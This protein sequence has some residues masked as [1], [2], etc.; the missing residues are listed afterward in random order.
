MKGHVVSGKYRWDVT[1]KHKLLENIINLLPLSSGMRSH[2]SSKATILFIFIPLFFSG[3]NEAS[4]GNNSLLRNWLAGYKD[5]NHRDDRN[6]THVLSRDA[7]DNDESQSFLTKEDSQ[8]SYSTINRR[9]ELSMW[10]ENSFKDHIEVFNNFFNAYNKFYEHVKNL[11]DDIT[12]WKLFED[13]NLWY[14]KLFN[15]ANYLNSKMQT[16][17][18]VTDA[19]NTSQ[20]QSENGESNENRKSTGQSG[21]S[22]SYQEVHKNDTCNETVSSVLISV[23]ISVNETNP[24]RNFDDNFQ[25]G[26]NNN[27]TNKG[28]KTNTQP[29][30]TGFKRREEGFNDSGRVSNEA[31]NVGMLMKGFHELIRFPHKYD[32]YLELIGK[33][34]ANMNNDDRSE[35][36][37]STMRRKLRPDEYRRKSAHNNGVQS[38]RHEEKEIHT[39]PNDLYEIKQIIKREARNSDP[40]GNHFGNPLLENGNDNTDRLTERDGK[41]VRLKYKGVKEVDHGRGDEYLKTLYE[42]VKSKDENPGHKGN[43]KSYYPGHNGDTREFYDRV[44]NTPE[45]VTDV[46]EKN[47]GRDRLKDNGNSDPLRKNDSTKRRSEYLE[48]RTSEGRTGSDS[49]GTLNPDEEEESPRRDKVVRLPNGTGTSLPDSTLSDMTWSRYRDS[50]NTYNK[51]EVV[52]VWSLLREKCKVNSVKSLLTKCVSKVKGFLNDLCRLDKTEIS[53]NS[54][55]TSRTL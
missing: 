6:Y 14:D 18:N 27:K 13:A 30:Y 28:N 29:E 10:F 39:E 5:G 26:Y 35:N 7:G 16:V 1:G 38:D 31:D 33:I 15:M 51:T 47:S 46:D 43:S 37:F 4:S 3:E 19:E 2:Y 22:K 48:G 49:G 25:G 52:D 45:K 17:G 21:H 41:W 20:R 42:F 23:N 9:G 8:D 53:D 12:R 32:R 11:P 44:Y 55:L 36:I 40:D 34:F 24:I 54:T 50:E